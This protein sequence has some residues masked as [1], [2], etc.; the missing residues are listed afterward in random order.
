MRNVQPNRCDFRAAVAGIEGR[1]QHLVQVPGPQHASG[2]SGVS[3]WMSVLGSKPNRLGIRSLTS[4]T[5]KSWMASGSCGL[6][7]V[8][9][10]QALGRLQVRAS[11]P[12]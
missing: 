1:L 12:G 8:E 2:S 3:T 11:G 10:A 5:I 7:E 4:R 9:V 6:D